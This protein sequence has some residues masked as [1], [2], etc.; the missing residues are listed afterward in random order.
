MSK[1]MTCTNAERG[2]PL[3]EAGGIVYIVCYLLRLSVYLL[4]MA[5]LFHYSRGLMA[6]KQHKRANCYRT[7]RG[8]RVNSCDGSQNMD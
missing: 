5:S 6:Y 1:L 8:K 7:V 4:K 2:R 3:C